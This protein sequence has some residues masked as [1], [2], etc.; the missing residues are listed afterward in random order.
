MAV[1]LLE[2]LKTRGI[3]A[4]LAVDLPGPDRGNH[5]L[6]AVTE[7]KSRDELDETATAFEAALKETRA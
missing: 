5:L 2:R 6:I 7:I 1:E 3:F 4:G